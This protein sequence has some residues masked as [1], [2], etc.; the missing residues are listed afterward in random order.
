MVREVFDQY[1]DRVIVGEIYLPVEQLVKYYGSEGPG[2]H[3]PFNFQLVTAPWDARGIADYIERYERLLPGGGWPNWVL[4]NHDKPRIATR[5]GIEQAR[6]AA[7]MLLTLRGTP[8]MYYGDEI[9]MRDV[10][11]PPD[12]IQDPLARRVPDRGR[13]PERTP[14]QWDSS[15]NAGFTRGSRWLPLAYDYRTVNV[16]AEREAPDSMLSLYQR[17]IDLRRSEPALEIGAYKGIEAQGDLLCYVRE[18]PDRRIL[19]A[20][21]LGGDGASF[22]L[23]SGWSG[24]VVVGTDRD[25][26]GA[27]VKGRVELAGNEGIVV[28]LAD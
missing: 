15:E 5:V 25:R 23:D 2:C 8:T 28:R 11:I 21:N 18:L 26:E 27:G 12:R 9:G 17:L 22:D 3:L 20:L 7:I 6:V 24:S 13:D 10:D 4:G 1:D 19:V 16:A 14:M